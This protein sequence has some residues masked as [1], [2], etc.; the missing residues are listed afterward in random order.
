L[1]VEAL[2]LKGARLRSAGLGHAELGRAVLRSVGVSDGHAVPVPVPVA[3]GR[4][5]ELRLIARIPRL[6][7]VRGRAVPGG[8]YRGRLVRSGLRLLRAILRPAIRPALLRSTIL[9]P[10]RLRSATVLAALLLTHM[11][12]ALGLLHCR[13]L[14]PKTRRKLRRL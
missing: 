13:L 11:L 2:L 14:L 1:L 7:P 8:G 5:G 10:A 12:L 9:R 4:A 6:V 3:G